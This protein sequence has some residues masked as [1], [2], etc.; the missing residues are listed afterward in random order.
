MT[1]SG[2]FGLLDIPAG[3]WASR[4]YADFVGRWPMTRRLVRDIGGQNLA[5]ARSF[6]ESLSQFGDE[7]RAVAEPATVRDQAGS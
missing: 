5:A 6:L 3:I 2:L 1:R 4:R 7:Q